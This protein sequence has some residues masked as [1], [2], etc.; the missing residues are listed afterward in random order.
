MSSIPLME[1]GPN[2]GPTS[3]QPSQAPGS[4]PSVNNL[5][6]PDRSLVLTGSTNDHL[7][8]PERHEVMQQQATIMN[9][10]E[11]YNRLQAP[12]I[13]SNCLNRPSNQQPLPPDS[14]PSPVANLPHLLCSSETGP[15]PQEASPKEVQESSSKGNEPEA[16]ETPQPT[17]ALSTPSPLSK[18]DPQSSS[19]QFFLRWD[20]HQ[21][22]L[23][24]V[25]E[26]LLHTGEMVDV[27]LTTD[28]GRAIKCHKVVL[29]ACSSYFR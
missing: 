6:V 7:V 2:P 27:T 17:T 23:T 18:E 22:N 12:Q 3:T 16:P 14:Q 1:G 8:M 4:N 10:Q 5:V 26:H 19:D 28:E 29:S 20:N 25:F 13:M 21:S 24:S 11:S 9:H 15:K